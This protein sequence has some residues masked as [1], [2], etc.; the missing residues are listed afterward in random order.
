MKI[1][2]KRLLGEKVKEL[3]EL[4]DG[5]LLGADVSFQAESFISLVYKG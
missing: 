3:N 1:S 2:Y 5:Q 4:G